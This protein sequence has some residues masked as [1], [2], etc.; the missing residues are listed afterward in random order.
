MGREAKFRKDLSMPGMVA[1]MR[2]CFERIK[3]GG[4]EP[5][6]ESAGLPDVGSGDLRAEVSVAAAVRPERP[7]SGRAVGA[8][9]EPAQ[10]VRDRSG[11]RAGAVRQL[12]SRPP[13]RTAPELPCFFRG[14]DI[15]AH[16]SELGPEVGS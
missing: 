4:V 11:A 8:G 3:D 13:G 6:A 7:G 12:L 14:T 5:G 16:A 1:E 2:R 15:A 9:G 10:P